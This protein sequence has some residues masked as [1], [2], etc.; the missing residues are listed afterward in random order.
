MWRAKWQEVLN[1]W[2]AVLIML[3]ALDLRLFDAWSSRV[4]MAFAARLAVE[5]PQLLQS[6]NRPEFPRNQ[7][8]ATSQEFRIFIFGPGSRTSA[9]GY[10]V[11][12][13]VI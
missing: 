10:W 4:D 3:I 13:G 1:I 12:T 8:S 5:A 2:A 9:G 11:R 7:L 6:S